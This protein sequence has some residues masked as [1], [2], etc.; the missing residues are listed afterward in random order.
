VQHAREH[1]AEQPHHH[2][3][4]RGRFDLV[5]AVLLGLT[6]M[7]IAWGAYRAEVN[8]THANHYF[9]RSELALGRAHKLELQGDQELAAD[10]QLFLELER[11][12]AEGRAKA[13]AFLR[14]HLLTTGLAR[15]ID[16]WERQPEATR[17]TTPFVAVNP[18]YENAFFARADFF[19]TGSARSLHKAHAAEELTVDYTLVIVV[20]TIGLFVLGLSTQILAPW[21]RFGLVGFGAVVLV[22]GL[23][24]FIDLAA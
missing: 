15:A 17:P 8:G 22:A 6:V 4:I 18:N 12:R 13:V 10:E 24:R 11:D 1:I 9:N 5:V 19:E 3:W 7:A 23:A 14:G 2:G 16:W 21:V 20:L